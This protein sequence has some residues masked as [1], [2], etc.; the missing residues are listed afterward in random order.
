PEMR[1]WLVA[2]GVGRMRAAEKSGARSLWS[3]ARLRP[4]CGPRRSA[5]EPE[6][7]GDVVVP[8]VDVGHEPD[9]RTVP[10]SGA[11]HQADRDQAF[12]FHV[13]LV[14]TRHRFL[15]LV[16]NAVFGSELEGEIER[17]LDPNAA[18]AAV[19]FRRRE[20]GLERRVVEIDLLRVVHVELD[21]PERILGPRQLDHAAVAHRELVGGEIGGT[22]L[23]QLV[24]I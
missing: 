13:I 6:R 1:T 16:R 19:A 24:V 22:L 15:E 8:A 17:I 3:D 12:Q 5:L 21:L 4:V 10:E 11:I 2:S 20:P 7:S 9:P 18:M 23:R 14:A